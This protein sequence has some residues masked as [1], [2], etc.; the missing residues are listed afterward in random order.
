MKRLSLLGLLAPVLIASAAEA[1]DA[2]T[3][4]FIQGNGRTTDLSYSLCG[5][6]R[7][8]EEEMKAS[9]LAELKWK[10]AY[11]ARGDVL[12]EAVNKNPDAFVYEAK[13]YCLAR[14][15]GATDKQVLQLQRENTKKVGRLDR[16]AQNAVMSMLKTNNQLA[17][18]HFC[19]EV[20]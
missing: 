3:S 1:R 18:K 9:F 15:Q 19:P 4:C 5:N 2:G 12:V 20:L 7:P 10:V 11:G 13:I 16:S 8:T 6:K 14:T 17:A